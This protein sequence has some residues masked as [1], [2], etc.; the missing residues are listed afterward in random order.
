MN[1]RLAI[2][3]LALA[4]ATA[5][6]SCTTEQLART[7]AERALVVNYEE[8]LAV[9]ELELSEAM[10]SGNS[11]AAATASA[12]IASLEVA[13]TTLEEE[14]ARGR[15]SG[16]AETIG[17]IPFIGAYVQP[18]S[19]FLI[20]LAPL[21]G[22]RGRKH[23]K[24]LV[25]NLNPFD[26]DGGSWTDALATLMKYIGISHSSPASEVAANAEETTA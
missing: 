8:Q 13:L 11:A 10:A 14:A 17:R 26:G 2:A 24:R 5:T 3:V 23:A 15:V 7:D 6:V 18:L 21:L 25:R 20:G 16:F 22:R 1:R 4:P 12:E 9:A 19:P